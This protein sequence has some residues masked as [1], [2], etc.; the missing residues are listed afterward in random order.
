MIIK[1]FVII[2]L[3]NKT[4]KIEFYIIYNFLIIIE[5]KAQCPPMT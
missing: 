1:N 2:G 5:T 3:Y 4:K